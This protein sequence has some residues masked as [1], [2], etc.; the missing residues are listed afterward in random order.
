MKLKGHGWTYTGPL[1]GAVLEEVEGGND[2]RALGPLLG[3]MLDETE[4]AMDGLC[5]CAITW[6]LSGC[7]WRRQ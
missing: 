7:S 5:T 2:G 1:L 3:T 4:E 6:H